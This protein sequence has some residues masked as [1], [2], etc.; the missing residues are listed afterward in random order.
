MFPSESGEHDLGFLQ[1]F[2]QSWE[3]RRTTLGRPVSYI[4]L[5]PLE[6]RRVQV[7]QKRKTNLSRS[8]R[9]KRSSRRTYDSA[10]STKASNSATNSSTSRNKSSIG[11]WLLWAG[12]RRLGG[13]LEGSLEGST[14][15]SRQ[16]ALENIVEETQKSST[17]VMAE[18]E[19]TTTIGLQTSFEHIEEH[20]LVNPYPDRAV[21]FNL[22]ELVDEFCVHTST[23]GLAP[24]LIFDLTRS[25]AMHSDWGLQ[26]SSTIPSCRRTASSFGQP[27][28]T[29][30]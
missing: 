13:K 29:T 18:S 4:A 24:C 27:C 17:E 22:L 15:Q 20:Q 26:S 21:L 14:E 10:S 19:T 7:A 25:P 16:M 9:T 3:Y 11:Q 8:D 5:A 6:R 30:R 2:E 23:A 28:W 12:R 1:R